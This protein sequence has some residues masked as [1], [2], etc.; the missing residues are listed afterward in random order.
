MLDS[1]IRYGVYDTA[2]GNVTLV[3]KGKKLIR[4]FFGSVDPRGAKNEENLALYDAIIELN[5]YSYGQRKIFDIDL[6]YI[7]N[8]DDKI[9]WD[10]CK[11]I[12]Y[13]ETHTLSMIID[14]TKLSEATIINSLHKNPLPIFIPTHRIVGDNGEYISFF[15]AN[16]VVA[17]KIYD[18]EKGIERVSQR[19]KQIKLV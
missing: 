13:G 14:A 7:E 12:P 3:A 5:Q 10:Y 17:K 19:K 11:N 9:V 8:G 15:P 2:F 16:D 6:N 1:I 4:L 18:I